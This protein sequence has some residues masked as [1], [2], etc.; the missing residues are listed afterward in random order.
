MQAFFF[1]F[2]STL[3]YIVSGGILLK[4]FLNR[5]IPR[6]DRPALLF[7]ILAGTLSH[8]LYELTGSP[9]IALFCPV[10]ESVWE[11]LKL[12]FFPYLAYSLWHFVRIRRKPYPPAYF[13][14]R[15]MGVLCGMLAIVMLFYTYTGISGRTVLALDILIF[16][17]G[18]FLSLQTV[19]FFTKRA[20]SIPSSTITYLMWLGITLCF[21]MFTCF[22][23]DIP[24]FLE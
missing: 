17:I 20:S 5:Y 11:H 22:P 12:L 15:L 1:I 24:L 10:N 23:P 8:F 13:Y 18:A 7:L 21:F 9:F 2:S 16:I 6:K 14:F 4:D 3:S 19:S